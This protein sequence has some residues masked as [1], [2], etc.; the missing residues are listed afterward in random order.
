M[1]SQALLAV[2]YAS[3]AIAGGGT[4]MPTDPA[5]AHRAPE[6]FP[7]PEL[8]DNPYMTPPVVWYQIGQIKI[9][10]DTRGVNYLRDGTKFETLDHTKANRQETKGQGTKA[11][12]QNIAAARCTINIASGDTLQTWRLWNEAGHVVTEG[13][14]QAG[15]TT[16]P[17]GGVSKGSGRNLARATVPTKLAGTSGGEMMSTVVSAEILL[18][19]AKIGNLW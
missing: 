10:T 9:W 4:Y 16:S 13:G 5:L 8:L 18:E 17:T 11:M 7:W 12:S 14:P 6:K 2:L 3:G 1:R 15:K 19:E